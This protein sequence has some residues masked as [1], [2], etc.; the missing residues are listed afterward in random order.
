MSV[1]REPPAGE[2]RYEHPIEVRFVDTDALGHVNNAVYLSYFEAARA[3]YYAAVAGAPFG[4]GERAGERTFVIAEAS[5]VYRRP[6]FFG[7]Q[8]W[9]GCRFAWTSRSSFGLEYRVRAGASALG[10]ARL[11]ADGTSTQ[12]MFDLARNRVMRVPAD[13]LEM[14]EAFE[15]RPIPRR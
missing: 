5:L 3:G 4:T 7:E 9:V 8:L 12:V 11:L 14:F 15:G 1:R 6:A 2:F 10:E 13:L